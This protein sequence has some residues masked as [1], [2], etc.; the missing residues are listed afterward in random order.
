MNRPA[1]VH[2]GC[3]GL[4][5]SVVR[6]VLGLIRRN[7]DKATMV[8]MPDAQLVAWQQV[9]KSLVRE[10]LAMK[11]GDAAWPIPETMAGI[12]IQIAT[13]YP[14]GQDEIAF[15]SER[16]DTVGRIR[17]LAIPTGWP[18]VGA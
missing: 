7:G 17:A 12:P 8:I 10:K 4:N 15:T 14:I 6:L 3:A 1:I 11:M 9:S 2:A 5:L 16:G 13:Y 18:R